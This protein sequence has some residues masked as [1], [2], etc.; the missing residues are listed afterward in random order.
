[1]YKREVNDNI[2]EA[3]DNFEDGQVILEATP[4][5]QQIRNILYSIADSSISSQKINGGLKVQVPVTLLESV[6]AKVDPETG[7][8][9][10]DE[11]KFYEKMVSVYV[12][13]W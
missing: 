4:A 9:V 13:L 10:S 1:M 2:I 12:R 5:Y 7:A 11:L 3:F 6:R 8:Y